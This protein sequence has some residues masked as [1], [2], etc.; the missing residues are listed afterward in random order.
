[1]IRRLQFALFLAVVGL[2]ASQ[3]QPRPAA[4]PG[5]KPTQDAQLYRNVTFGFR[6]QI[7][8]GWVDRTKEMRDEAAAETADSPQ[9][10]VLLAAFE[11]PPDA[12][13]DNVNSAVVIAAERVADYPKLKKA[14]DYLE[15]LTELTTAK[16]FEADGEPSVAQIDGRQLVRA[17][18]IKPL[19]DKITMHQAT[20]I[21]LAKGQIVFFTFV[22]GGEDEI[23]NLIG[24]LHFSLAK[25][26]AR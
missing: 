7:R 20:L 6:Y 18:F 5:S 1:M 23:E 16:G 26:P 21:F 2:A 10:E 15:P 13:A 11:R 4:Q 22:A 3:T 25:Q 12:P 8:Y 9:G 19:T 17:D 14:E 24:S